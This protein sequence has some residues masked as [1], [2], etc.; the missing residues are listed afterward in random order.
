[1]PKPQ[2]LAV[3]NSISNQA[4]LTVDP[5]LVEIYQML[6]E[7]GTD[8]SSLDELEQMHVFGLAFYQ[9]VGL[10]ISYVASQPLISVLGDKPLE[11]F[12]RS[13]KS[14]TCMPAPP[15]IEL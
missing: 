10:L 14:S 4:N 2:A 15:S 1:M 13:R 8:D 3:S 7:R 9:Q 5:G 12:L 11:N 6:R